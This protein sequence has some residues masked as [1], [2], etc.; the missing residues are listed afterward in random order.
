MTILR[1]EQQQRLRYR[2]IDAFA[3]A[4]VGWNAGLGRTL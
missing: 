3:Q 4:S 1:W 2:V